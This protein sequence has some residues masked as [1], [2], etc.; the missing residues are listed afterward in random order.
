MPDVRGEDGGEPAF[1]NGG[2]PPAEDG[3]TSQ[4]RLPTNMTASF[5]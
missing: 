4:L 2:S 1:M 5:S 3:G